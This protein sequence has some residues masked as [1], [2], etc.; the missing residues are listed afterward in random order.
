MPNHPRPGQRPDRDRANTP[1]STGS[2][3]KR[4]LPMLLAAF[5]GSTL[6]QFLFP[7]LNF[8]VRLLILAVLLLAVSVVLD[9]L[10]SR[11]R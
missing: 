11:N 3:L 8:V 6:L 9:R 1:T 4:L 7:E 2:Y 5:L 10:R